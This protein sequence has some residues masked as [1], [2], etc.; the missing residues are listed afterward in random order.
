MKT[1][2]LTVLLVSSLLSVR[3][4]APPADM[5]LAAAEVSKSYDKAQPEVR[6]FVLQTARS[7]GSNGMWLNE[8]AYATLKPEEFEARIA[9]LTKLF[10]ESEYGRHLVCLERT[11]RSRQGL[12]PG[13]GTDGL[14]AF[15]RRSTSELL[16]VFLLRRLW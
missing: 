11:A 5:Q 1:P 16:S 2:A 15:L 6:E 7:F 9:Y 4:D 3:A 10:A 8:N 14:P 13:S 12:F